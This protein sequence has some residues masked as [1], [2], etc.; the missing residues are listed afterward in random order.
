MV[1]SLSEWGGGEPQNTGGG[2]PAE[3]CVAAEYYTLAANTAVLLG[4]DTAPP[5][6]KYSE[7]SGM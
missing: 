1:K 5:L 2:F 7:D 3:Q 6:S 4:T